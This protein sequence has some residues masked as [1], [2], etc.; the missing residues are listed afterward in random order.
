MYG[1][2]LINIFSAAGVSSTNG[3]RLFGNSNYL[4]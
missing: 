2:L 3:L 1:M 4:L